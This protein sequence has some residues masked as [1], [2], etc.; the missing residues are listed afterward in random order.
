MG[1][2]GWIDFRDK[3]GSPKSGIASFVIA[4]KTNSLFLFGVSVKREI[5]GRDIIPL[6]RLVYF[7]EPRMAS[8]GIIKEFIKY[9]IHYTHW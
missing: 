8:T 4:L 6:C 3:C 2:L 9:A 7:Y 1:A 5:I